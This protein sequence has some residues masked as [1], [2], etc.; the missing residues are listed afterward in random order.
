MSEFTGVMLV[1]NVEELRELMSCENDIYE[2]MVSILR[3][4]VVVMENQFATCVP[5][6]TRFQILSKPWRNRITN[7][8]RCSN[9][10]SIIG[11]RGKAVPREQVIWMARENPQQTVHVTKISSAPST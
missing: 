7:R 5:G 3:R 4:F 8:R 6:T 9:C 2:R 11:A 10:L 1:D